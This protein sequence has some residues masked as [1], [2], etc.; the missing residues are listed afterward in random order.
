MFLL[1]TALADTRSALTKAEKGIKTQHKAD[2]ADIRAMTRE[3]SP[4]LS[5]THTHTNP[6]PPQPES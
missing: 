5:L 1:G 6:Y 2:Y 4:P 3:L